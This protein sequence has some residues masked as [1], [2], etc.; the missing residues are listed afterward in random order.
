MLQTLRNEYVEWGGWAKRF[1][2]DRCYCFTVHQLVWAGLHRQFRTPRRI[3]WQ[4]GGHGGGG[5]GI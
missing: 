3:T 1:F 2:V 5:H 4:G